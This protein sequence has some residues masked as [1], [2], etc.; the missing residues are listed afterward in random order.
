SDLHRVAK[1]D[2]TFLELPDAGRQISRLE[3]DAIPAAGLLVAAVRHRPRTRRAWAAENQ[4]EP[5]QGNL[6]ERRQV[7]MGQRESQHGGIEFDRA[8]DVL[9]LVSDAPRTLDHRR[10]GALGV[11]RSSISH[12]S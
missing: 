3:D 7:L 5:A 8:A 10:T 1:A 2:P 9:H 11:A 4:L 12:I 6:T